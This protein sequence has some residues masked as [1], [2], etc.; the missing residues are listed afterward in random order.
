MVLHL[1][2]VDS[3]GHTF[4]SLHG[5]IERKLKDTEKIIEQIVE[6]MDD[7]T[8][9]LIFGDHGMTPDGNHGGLT[10]LEM[11][12]A[13]FAYQKTP[14]PM[15]KHYNK[16]ALNGSFLDMDKALKQLD[17]TPIVSSLLKQP[18]PFSNMG[19]IHPIFAPT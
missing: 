12:S 3:A 4:H 14:F 11:R 6:K 18:V 9:L 2:G 19:I 10:E 17:I 8:T 15:Y 16:P 7:Q 13:L 5:E 1:I